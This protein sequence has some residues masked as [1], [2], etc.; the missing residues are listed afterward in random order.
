MIIIDDFIK[1]YDFLER[2]EN[3]EEF[4]KKGYRWYDGWWKD[5]I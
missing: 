2:I 4:W 5:G 1:D 3:D